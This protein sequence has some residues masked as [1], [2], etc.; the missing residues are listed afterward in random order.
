MTVRAAPQDQGTG[1]L[2]FMT[3]AVWG[4]SFLDLFLDFVLPSYLAPSMIPEVWKSH[5]MMVQR[6]V[7]A[8]QASPGCLVTR[9]ANAKA[10]GT[11]KPT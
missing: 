5:V 7:V 10:N 2:V 9:E 1:T 4:E 8:I 3:V 11:V 6:R